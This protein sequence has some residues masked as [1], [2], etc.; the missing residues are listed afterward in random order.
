VCAAA[1]PVLIALGVIF[2]LAVLPPGTWPAKLIGTNGMACLIFI[3][4]IGLGP[5]AMFLLALR[6]GAPMNPAGAGAV[7]GLLAGGIA[8]GLYAIHCT[9]D[10]PLFVATWYTIA[11]LLLAIIGAAAAYRFVRW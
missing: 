2:E 10:S 1:A 3:T 9:D 5:L 4:L 7:A 6:Y 8:A 11:I